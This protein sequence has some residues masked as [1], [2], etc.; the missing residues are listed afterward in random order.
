MTPATRYEGGRE[1][2]P[3][4]IH[5]SA[6]QISELVRANSEAMLQAWTTAMR[7]ML[8]YQEHFTRFVG[9]RMQKDM[10][11]ARDMSGCRDIEQFVDHQV[12]F[13]RNMMNDYQHAGEV[14]LQSTLDIIRDSARPLEARAEEA[15][16]EVREAVAS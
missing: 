9:M 16:H 7:G 4:E 10:E 15:P 13:G 6:M 5:G 2:A 14:L 3:A 12:A 11:M 1:T 8:N